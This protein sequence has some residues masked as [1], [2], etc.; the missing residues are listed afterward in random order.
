MLLPNFIHN[1]QISY[2]TSRESCNNQTL[3][4]SEAY[5]KKY[6]DNNKFLFLYS[7]LSHLLEYHIFPTDGC[8]TDYQISGLTPVMSE[9]L[10]RWLP[11]FLFVNISFKS[12]LVLF[13]HINHCVLVAREFY[14]NRQYDFKFASKF[15]A[16]KMDNERAGQNGSS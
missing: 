1:F 12:F 9:E 4:K 8:D 14:D 7:R 3:V 6:H 5:F 16:P 15:N 13:S 11:K 10:F 2:T